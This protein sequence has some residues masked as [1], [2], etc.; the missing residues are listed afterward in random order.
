MVSK[1]MVNM[2]NSYVIKDINV[3]NQAHLFMLQAQ[4]AVLGFC[5][6]DLT[7][8]QPVLRLAHFTGQPVVNLW[9]VEVRALTG[10]AA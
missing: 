7:A 8:Q 9:T 1:K 6:A 5:L 3:K 10:L 4:P 2:V